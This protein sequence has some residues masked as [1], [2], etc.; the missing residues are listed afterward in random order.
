[1][2][3][4]ATLTPG[5]AKNVTMG[6]ENSDRAN[7]SAATR[8]PH[9]ASR[10]PT[11]GPTRP[12]SSIGTSSTTSSGT[13]ATRKTRYCDEA[14]AVRR[15]RRVRRG[16]RQHGSWWTSAEQEEQAGEHPERRRPR[17]AQVARGRAE[18]GR[19]GRARGCGSTAKTT[20]AGRFQLAAVNVRRSPSAT[21]S[22]LAPSSQA[23]VDDVLLARRRRGR[24]EAHVDGPDG[25]GTR[26]DG[27]SAGGLPTVRARNA[28]SG[29]E[30]V[31]LHHDGPPSASAAGALGRRDVARGDVGGVRLRLE[32]VRLRPGARPASG[33]ASRVPRRRCAAGR[34]RPRP[35][36]AAGSERRR[37][38]LGRGRTSRRA[39][40]PPSAGA[41]SRS[42]DRMRRDR[43]EGASG[44]A[45][46]RSPRPAAG[47]STPRGSRP[48]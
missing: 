2:N 47:R 24:R 32:R 25:P 41:G 42:A 6:S 35:A 7:G 10:L 5:L 40:L 36:P 22:S 27:A 37:R 12:Q 21:V 45:A 11:S 8:R 38:L 34:P 44:R 31:R 20:R 26:R 39:G 23:D 33:S 29:P 48:G 1:M 16:A 17:E 46:T 30:T 18:R 3:A 43:R 15:A 14:R 19:G 9:G 4:T 13:N 28:P